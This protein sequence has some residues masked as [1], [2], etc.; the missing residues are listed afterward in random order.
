MRRLSTAESGFEAEFTA[1]L[2]EARKTTERVDQAVSAI[3]AAVR[4]RGD[5]ALLDF[6]ARFDR[7]NLTQDRLR[8]TEAEIDAAVAVISSGVMAALDLAARRIESFHSQA[9]AC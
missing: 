1:L 2:G 4:A 5:A 9:D 7:L 8:I 3:I 6:T